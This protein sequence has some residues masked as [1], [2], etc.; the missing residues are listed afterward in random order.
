MPRKYTE[1][2]H[3][4]WKE[5]LPAFVTG[6]DP[7][8]RFY[9]GIDIVTSGK[10][11][12]IMGEYHSAIRWLNSSTHSTVQPLQKFMG[13]KKYR[14]VTDTSGVRHRLL[15]NPNDLL[16]WLRSIEDTGAYDEALYQPQGGRGHYY[17][18]LE[19]S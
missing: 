11:S 7:T 18:K 4:L 17:R 16:Q 19:A 9:Y 10:N 14:Y 15:T 2:S 13:G 5:G 8:H 6:A 3:I 12:K 1:S